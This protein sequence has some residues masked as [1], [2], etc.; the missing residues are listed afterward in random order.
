M[1]GHETYLQTEPRLSPWI[2]VEHFRLEASFFDLFHIVHI[3]TDKVL[4]AGVV[5]E[6]EFLGCL[7]QAEDLQGRL[8]SLWQAFL[9]FCKGRGMSMGKASF[10]VGALKFDKLDYPELP[11]SMKAVACK[12]FIRFLSEY[13]S[14]HPQVKQSSPTM[15]ACL[16]SLVECLDTFDTG[17]IILSP[18][19][20]KKAHDLGVAHLQLYQS[21]AHS[22]QQA[23]HC[24]FNI[25]PKHHYFWHILRSVQRNGLNPAIVSNTSRDET[26]MG[27]VKSVG[28]MTRGGGL[29][30]KRALQRHLLA[31]AIRWGVWKN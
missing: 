17:G 11:S 14:S 16:Q 6:L 12:N 26:F 9:L 5:H 21:L 31:L 10:T 13:C 22:A 25:L 2:Q 7:P 8:D 3:G 1:L 18:S 4:G 27:R 20:A 23:G 30:V 24:R 15:V 28:R 19:A 29:V